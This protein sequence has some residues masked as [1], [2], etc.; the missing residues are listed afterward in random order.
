MSIADSFR[1]QP[2]LPLRGA[3]NDQF[4]QL[5]ME[6]FQPTLPLRGATRRFM[7]LAHAAISFNPRS[8]CGERQ[9]PV[10]GGG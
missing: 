3:T 7:P 1:F 9:P 4:C 6:Q 2:T 8:P 10:G 5:K